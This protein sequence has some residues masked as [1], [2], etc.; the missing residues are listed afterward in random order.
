MNGQETVAEFLLSEPAN[1]ANIQ[2][3]VSVTALSGDR[4]VATWT[5]KT[6]TGFDI[7]AAIFGS[8]GS[9]LSG[10]FLVNE[11]TGRDQS[12]SVVTEME[13]GELMFAWDS[14]DF[15]QDNSGQSVKARL[16][17]FDGE[18]QSSEFLVNST[19]FGNQN[20]VD[21]EALPGNRF[22]AAWVSDEANFQGVK[23]AIFESDGTRVQD[24]D[25]VHVFANGGQ[26]SPKI[27]S[28]EGG[29]FII[30]WGSNGTRAFNDASAVHAR[31]YDADYQPVGTEFQVNVGEFG[32]QSQPDVI[33]LSNGGSRSPG[34]L[35]IA[36]RVTIV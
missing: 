19:T 28:L 36:Q 29:G 8:D 6:I 22:A 3:L 15:V 30:V 7:K 16:F 2:A 23:F 26:G 24:E 32:I 13:N 14:T 25:W 18:P 5:S 9:R 27:A 31:I 12:N 1:S 35:M 4:F 21:I 34:N 11:L 33:A 17:S 20:F 10:E